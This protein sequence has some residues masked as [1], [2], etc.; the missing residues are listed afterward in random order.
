VTVAPALAL[1]F[2]MKR[3]RFVEEEIARRY[4]ENHMRCPTHLSTG[5]EGVAAAVGLALRRDD[6]AVSGHRAHAHYLGKGGNL[7]AMLAE[8]YG[9]ATGCARGHGGS[10]HLVDES[11]GFMGSTA[12]VAGTV[13][14]GVGLAYGIKLKRTDQVSCVFLG[15]AAT[16]AGVFFESVNFAVVKRLPVIFICENN[17]YS[18][19]SPLRVRQPEGRRI[20]D[21]VGGLGLPATHGN[22]NDAVD[23]WHQTTAALAGIRADGGPRFL[24][25]STYRWREHCGPLYDNDLGYRSE[26]EFLEW[27]EKDP[28]DTLASSLLAKADVSRERIRQMDTEIEHEV[29][30]AFE[31]AESSPDP[32]PATASARLYA[33]RT[34]PDDGGC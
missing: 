12:I 14:V 34:S 17:L 26:A 21:M 23:V 28:I 32:D 13:P 29:N 7:A 27:K 31:F 1:L 33:D 8:L 4:A 5:Q 25:F 22:G 11:V 18:V 2:Q 6:L 3:I 16:E 9:K 24:E 20:Y 10:M 30:A 19:Y 15:D